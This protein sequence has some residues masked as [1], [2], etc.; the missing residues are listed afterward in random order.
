VTQDLH[1]N[2]L[3][4]LLVRLGRCWSW[5]MTYIQW[6]HDPHPMASP[7]N[8]FINDLKS[9]LP[10]HTC[11]TLFSWFGVQNKSCQLRRSGTW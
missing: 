1:E 3:L 10:G 9:L 5:Q 11:Q 2:G 8:G 6:L 4:R 7:I